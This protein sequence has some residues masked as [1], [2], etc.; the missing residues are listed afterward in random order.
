MLASLFFGCPTPLT[1][2]AAA[3]KIAIIKLICGTVKC[4]VHH[5]LVCRQK[6]ELN[7]KNILDK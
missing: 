4:Q 2:S 6:K 5:Q 3:S 7:F 1:D